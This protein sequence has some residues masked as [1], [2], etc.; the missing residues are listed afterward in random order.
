MRRWVLPAL[1]VAVAGC[2][3]S[4]DG[5]ALFQHRFT[6]DEGL[7]P[8]FNAASCGSC[9][10]VP[11]P[12]GTGRGGLAT[13]L[14]AGRMPRGGGDARSSVPAPAH[15]LQ[16]RCPAGIPAGAEVTSVR[17]APTLFGA[18]R[19]AAIPDAAIEAA[20]AAEPAA[21]RGRP[22]HVGGRIGR[23]GWK[24]DVATVEAFVI[25]A[26]HDELGVTS[27]A[28]PGGP[29]QGTEAEADGETVRALSGFVVGLRAPA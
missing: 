16:A 29:C 9:H 26:L 1:V 23:F 8:R 7:G 20:A 18:G 13:A 6:A 21:V 27:P 11:A 5:A 19:I 28:A 25:Q 22:N 17:N 12:G 24:A 3:S 2:G 10:A 4:P 15:T 14:R